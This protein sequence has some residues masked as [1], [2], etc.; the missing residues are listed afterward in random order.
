MRI[1]RVVLALLLLCCLVGCGNGL[2]TP[3][4]PLQAANTTEMAPSPTT[5]NSA[6]LLVEAQK[7]LQA[8]ITLNASYKAALTAAESRQNQ[9]IAEAATLTG[10]LVD[11]KFQVANALTYKTELEALQEINTDLQRKL[12]EA[13]QPLEY[14]SSYDELLGWFYGVWVGFEDCDDVAQKAREIAEADGYY[15]GEV[16]VSGYEYNKVFLEH[17]IPQGVYHAINFTWVG[18]DGY[19]VDFGARDIKKAPEFVRD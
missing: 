5:D 9:A 11:Y 8:Q 13:L 19:Y 12:D 17:P 6:A 1:M 10:Q 2:N 4:E 18:N 14:F 16:I 7:E 15:L 3:S